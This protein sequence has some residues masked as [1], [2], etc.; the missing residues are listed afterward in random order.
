MDYLY[1]DVQSK[2]GGFMSTGFNA[3]SSLVKGHQIMIADKLVHTT[4]E[5]ARQKVLWT[6]LYHNSVVERLQTEK[7]E[8]A[9]DWSQLR[10]SEDQIR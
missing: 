9:K 4:G 8:S 2:P 5:R 6:A 1:A 10:I 7:H 3:A